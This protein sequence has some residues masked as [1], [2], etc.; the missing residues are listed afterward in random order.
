VQRP[1]EAG[2]DNH[3]RAQ[4]HLPARYGGFAAGSVKVRADAAFLTGSVGALDE[5]KRSLGVA[6]VNQL[7]DLWPA[8]LDKMDL[9]T[10]NLEKRG[11][12]RSV[13]HWQS[14]QPLEHKRPQKQW[15]A[16]V[17]EGLAD[18][19]LSS[20]GQ[21]HAVAIQSSAASEASRFLQLP[22][23]SGE[24]VSDETF[25]TSAR[26]RLGLKL[27]PDTVPKAEVCQ[28]IRRKDGQRCGARLDAEGHHECICEAGGALDRRHNAARDLL[29]KRLAEDLRIPVRTE[30]RCPQWDRLDPKSQRIVEA[31]LDIIVPIGETTYYV[32][33]TV[34]DPLSEDS[35]LERQRAKKPGAAAMTAEDRKLQKYAG[36]TTVPF[37]VESYGRIGPAGLAW[38]KRA[39]HDCP[40]SMQSLLSEMSALIHSHTSGMILAACAAP[41]RA[42]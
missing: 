12:G 27:V 19:L 33:V 39:Y 9:A 25:R 14:D 16:A 3:R 40:A 15:T 35:A 7:R 32:D 20:A 6:T 5:V 17:Q 38:L 10:T 8:H 42:R 37:A 4:I 18:H 29:A 13:R 31:R 34:V 24:R 26:R 30:Q 11:A 36:P 23:S 2:L 41:S 28:N 1:S 22:G 21:R